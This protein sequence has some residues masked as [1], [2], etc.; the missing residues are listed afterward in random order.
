MVLKYYLK[1]TELF[2]PTQHEQE[3]INR[4]MQI[5]TLQLQGDDNE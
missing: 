1:Q 4:A 2:S 3:L 5:K